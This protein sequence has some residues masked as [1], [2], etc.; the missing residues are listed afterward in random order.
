[1]ASELMDAPQ[2][3]DGYFQLTLALPAEVGDIVP[4][5]H[6]LKPGQQRRQVHSGKANHTFHIYQ[7]RKRERER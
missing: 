4:A 5:A 3:G 7:G 6:R 1:M 2:R